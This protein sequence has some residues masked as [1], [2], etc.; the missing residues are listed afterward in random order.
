MSS[1][2]SISTRPFTFDRHAAPL[3]LVRPVVPDGVM[4]H[5][6]VVP[7]RNV[8]LR[9]SET[10]LKVDLLAVIEEKREQRVAFS[11]RQLVDAGRERAVDEER[12]APGFRMRADHRMRGR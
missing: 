1:S 2:A 9:P 3:A 7:E 5:A 4:H 10:N 12:L 6:A 8:V 11:L